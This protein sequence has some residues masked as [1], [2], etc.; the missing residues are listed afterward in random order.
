ML[1]YRY[2]WAVCVM[3]MYVCVLMCMYVCVCVWC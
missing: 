2:V 3:C 1:V